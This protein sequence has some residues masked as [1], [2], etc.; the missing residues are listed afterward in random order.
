MSQVDVLFTTDAVV[1]GINLPDCSSVIRF[2]L[3]RTVSSYAQ[4]QKQASQKDLKY[5]TMLER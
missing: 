2:D 4:S 5:I 1:E 3:P